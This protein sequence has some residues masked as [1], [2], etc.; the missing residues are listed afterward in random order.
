MNFPLNPFL[1]ICFNLDFSDLLHI[2]PTV[3]MLHPTFYFCP[4]QLMSYCSSFSKNVLINVTLTLSPDLP[5]GHWFISL[6]FFH[7]FLTPLQRNL[8]LSQNYKLHP[9][10]K[11]LKCSMLLLLHSNDFSPEIN[12]VLVYIISSMQYL[13]YIL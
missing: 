9:L 3:I 11:E 2:L 13:W 4:T 1:A 12:G 8:H 5:V 7:S 6:F 10:L